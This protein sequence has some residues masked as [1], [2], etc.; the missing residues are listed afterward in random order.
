MQREIFG[1]GISV[2]R[3]GAKLMRNR[4]ARDEPT[5][6]PHSFHVEMKR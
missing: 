4:N 3:A 6:L 5:P 1:D 2:H